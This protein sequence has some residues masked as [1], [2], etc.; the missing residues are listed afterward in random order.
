MIVVNNVP[1]HTETAVGRESPAQTNTDPPP[2][3][4]TPVEARQPTPVGYF[5]SLIHI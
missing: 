1:G 2:V 3:P 5:L 4:Q